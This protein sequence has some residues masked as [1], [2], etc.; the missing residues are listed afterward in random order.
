MSEWQTQRL[1]FV[2][3][4]GLIFITLKLTGYI[5]WSWGYVLSPIILHIVFHSVREI[6]NKYWK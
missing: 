1:A 2:Q 5:T 6:L 4:L 3:V